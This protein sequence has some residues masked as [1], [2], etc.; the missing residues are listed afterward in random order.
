MVDLCCLFI[1]GDWDELEDKTWQVLSWVMLFLK[2]VAA[3]CFNQQ[4]STDYALLIN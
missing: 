3:V 1:E 4:I 2:V